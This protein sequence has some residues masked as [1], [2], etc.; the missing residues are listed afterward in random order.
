MTRGVLM[1]PGQIV[2]LRAYGG[3]ELLRRVIRQD[4]GLLV[5][6]SPEEYEKAHREKREPVGVGFRT[7][8]V[9]DE[10]DVM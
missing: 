10:V 6:C 1:K 4:N 9:I 2:K 3:E 8:D 7:K 5:V